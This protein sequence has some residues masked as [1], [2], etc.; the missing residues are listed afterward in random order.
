VTRD[1]PVEAFVLRSRDLAENDR[2]LTLFTREH[3]RV[4]AI[5]RGA[6]KPGSRLAGSTDTLSYA[7]LMLAHGR[8]FEYVTQ[9]QPLRAFVNIRGDLVRLAHAMVFAEILE[10]TSVENRPNEPE[11]DLALLVMELLDGETDPAAV[12]LWG[13]NRFLSLLGYAPVLDMCARCREPGPPV[14]AAF[15]PGAGGLVCERCG[16]ALR[17]A[18][19]L[20]PAAVSEWR[21]LVAAEAPPDGLA[22]A[23]ALRRAMREAWRHV[24][25]SDLRSA[26][27]L[28][29]LMH[30]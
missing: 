4:S 14:R 19:P 11:Y 26:Q 2:I 12:S 22:A 27:F 15:S 25:D 13:E 5:A 28:E 21:S 29:E 3:G 9:S 8:Q 1:Y 18:L 10:R 16:A 17:D 30:Q 24:L 23:G 6:R 20:P 7:R